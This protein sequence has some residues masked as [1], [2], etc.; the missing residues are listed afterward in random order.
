MTRHRFWLE[1]R[2][3]DTPAYAVH[4]FVTI[5][6]VLLSAH[7][8]YTKAGGVLM[9]ILDWADPFLLA[10]KASKYLSRHPA[11]FFQFASDRLF[12]MFAV[13]FV[14]TRNIMFTYVVYTAVVSHDEEEEKEDATVRLLLKG[15]LVILAF[16]MLYWL[17]LILQAAAYQ[18]F[19]RGNVDDIRE[20]EVI[21]RI[22]IEKQKT[23]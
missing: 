11:D 15:M 4:H 22:A 9:Y 3:S 20:D 5:F 8:H 2:R 13:V 18:R 21:Q 23:A 6:L 19:N 1:H 17:G 7:A 10:A 14:V 16:L 12:E